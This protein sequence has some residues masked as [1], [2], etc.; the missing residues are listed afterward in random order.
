M[1]FSSFYGLCLFWFECFQSLGDYKNI[2]VRVLYWFNEQNNKLINRLV[3]TE[4]ID[5]WID[6]LSKTVIYNIAFI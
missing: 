5:G 4:C 1:R 3:E 6:E 2:K